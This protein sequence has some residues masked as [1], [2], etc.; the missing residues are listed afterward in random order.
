MVFGGVYDVSCTWDV[1]EKSEKFDDAPA[2]LSFLI[3]K[4]KQIKTKR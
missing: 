2:Q 3:H 1:N 4:K